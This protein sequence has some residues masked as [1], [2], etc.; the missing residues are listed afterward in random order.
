MKTLPIVT[1]TPEQLQII[2]RNRPGV[3]VIRG[4]AGSGKTTTAILRLHSLIATFCNRRLRSADQS[5]VRVLVLTYNRTLRGYI[6]ELVVN[7]VPQANNVELEVS[8]FASWAYGQLGRPNVVDDEQ[9]RREIRRLGAGIPLEPQFLVGEVEYLIGRFA[10]GDLDQYLGARRDGR[11]ASP[12]VD[13]R[14]RTELLTSVVDPYYTWLRGRRQ[15]D[16][17]DLAC[18][19][20]QQPSIGYDIVVV[21]ESQDLSANEIRAIISHLAEVHALTFVLDTI[22]R[23][24]ARGYIWREV[25]VAI[26]P[27]NVRRLSRNYRNTREIASFARALLDGLPVDDDGTIPDLSACTRSGPLPTV[28]VGRYERQVSHM[29]G[30]LREIDLVNQSVAILHIKGGGWFSF[31]EK[32]LR[33][34]G[35]GF[36]SITRQSEWPQGRENIALS[37]LHS[38]KGLEFDHV[39]LIG[40]N[41]ELLEHSDDDPEEDRLQ[42][43]KR[44]L[45]MG[46]SRARESVTLGY[47]QDEAPRLLA[48]VDPALYRLVDL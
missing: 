41:Q 18:E 16:W 42:T 6:R 15:Q 27:E 46:V 10:P 39:F 14:L 35:F 2:S 32:S 26:R 11:G 5:A 33:D 48:A 13:R 22:Q 20:G 29:L 47:R 12:R 37:T 19:M 38:S 9:R 44:L 45:A 17:N 8:T 4:A 25:G 1:P 24:Y 3:E 36:A 40:M 28:L 43:L 34:N 23:I 30:R 7:Q 31:V 21:D